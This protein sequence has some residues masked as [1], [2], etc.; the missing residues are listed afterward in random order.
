M[1]PTI[2]RPDTGLT[3]G[4]AMNAMAPVPKDAPLMIAWEAYK[5]T[6]DYKNSHS[7]ATRFIPDD[8]PAE[9]ERVRAS[10]ANYF[11]KEQRIMAVEGSLWA[12]FMNG[13]QGQ[14]MTNTDD[15]KAMAERIERARKFIATEYADPSQLPKGDWISPAAKPAHDALCLVLEQLDRLSAQAQAQGS[16]TVKVTTIRQLADDPNSASGKSLRDVPVTHPSAGPAVRE[17]GLPYGIIDPDYAAFFTV[18][19]LVAWSYGYG[20]GLH[21]SFTRDL[22]LILV[23]WTDRANPDPDHVLKNIESR[24]GWKRIKDDGSKHPHG[25]LVWTLTSRRFECP[26]F[27]DIGFMPLTTPDTRPDW[28]QDKDETTR[29]KPKSNA[30]KSGGEG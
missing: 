11:G 23:P 26:R 10:G 7:W 8:D 29:I 3:K 16:G 5:E 17:E 21:G 25:R 18:A 6:D 30:T 13:Y 4:S 12:A 19:R 27:I 28:K 24:S 22:D 20:V 1:T 14:A 15:V 2:S 9:V